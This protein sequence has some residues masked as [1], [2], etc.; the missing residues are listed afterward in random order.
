MSSKWGPLFERV[1]RV[2]LCSS[3]TLCGCVSLGKGGGRVYATVFVFVL[4]CVIAT[5][6]VL[7]IW[8]YIAIKTGE[9]P[10]LDF[11][12][13]FGIFGGM[14]ALGFKA[15]QKKFEQP[16]CKPEFKRTMP[17]DME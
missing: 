11:G 4:F 13:L 9:F 17:E 2:H 10:K 5:S 14:G 6:Y 3:V 1:S 7:G 8:G 15:V 16:F 12:D